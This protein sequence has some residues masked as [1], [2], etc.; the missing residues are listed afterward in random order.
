MT[1]GDG[2]PQAAYINDPD[3]GRVWFVSLDG[4]L[5]LEVQD[6]PRDYALTEIQRACAVDAVGFT[7]MRIRRSFLVKIG[8]AFDP[9]P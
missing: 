8:A 6:D 4:E 5:F 9:E 3:L 2:P 7:P 1:P